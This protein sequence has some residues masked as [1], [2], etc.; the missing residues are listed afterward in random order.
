MGICNCKDS[1]YEFISNVE[2]N[3]LGIKCN[4]NTSTKDVLEKTL[5]RI[6]SIKYANPERFQSAKQV[7]DFVNKE[8]INDH[9]NLT[10]PKE[11]DDNQNV[12][13]EHEIDSA[14]EEMIKG[15]LCNHFLF[16]DMPQDLL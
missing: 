2:V 13:F 14:E 5:L 10:I 8:D 6:K 7:S 12:I 1:K 16:K 4:S 3:R 9:N 11:K 15:A